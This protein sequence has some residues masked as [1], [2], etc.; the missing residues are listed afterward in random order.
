MSQVLESHRSAHTDSFARDHLPPMALWPVL[1]YTLPELQYPS[2]LNCATELLDRHID[3]GRSARTAILFP[4]GRWSYADLL[5]TSN[6]IANTLVHDFGIVPG[7]RV[8][9]RAP[10]NPMLAACWF[11]VLKAGGIVVCTMPLLRER[12]LRFIL[13]H[14]Q[15]NLALTDERIAD[16]LEQAVAQPGSR[17]VPIVRFRELES[18]AASR[19]AAFVNVATAADDVAIIAYTSG[20]TG[21]AKG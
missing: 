10:N 21:K 5:A 7:N 12:E 19:S 15:V 6:R 16:A 13:D 18:L 20:T 8:L 9:L 1:E 14:A 3:E 17:K 2:R 4:G 11:A